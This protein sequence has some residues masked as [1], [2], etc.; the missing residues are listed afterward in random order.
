[1]YC[2]VCDPLSLYLCVCPPPSLMCVASFSLFLCDVRV[3][4]FLWVC[5]YLP[6]RKGGTQ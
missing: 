4:S 6:H 1:M 3:S 2:V 5:V